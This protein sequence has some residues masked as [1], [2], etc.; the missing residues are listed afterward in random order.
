MYVISATAGEVFTYIGYVIAAVLAL[1]VMIVIHELGHYTAGKLFGFKIDEFAIGFGPA[2]IKKRNKKTGELFTL[3]PFPIGGFCAFHG[4]DAEGAMV[5][6]NGNQIKDENGN[7]VKDPDAF[8]NQ[9]PWKRL[10]VLLSGAFMNFLSAIV[11]ITIYFTAYGQLL[12]NVVDVHNTATYQNVFQEGDVIL[13]INGKQVNIMLQEDLDNA[14]KDLSD[15]SYFW[16]L[17]G[18]KR[19][20]ITA[21]KFYYQPFDEDD[22]IAVINGKKLETP[23]KASA[24]GEYVEQNEIDSAQ[25]ITLVVVKYG[26]DGKIV[27]QSSMSVQKGVVASDIDGFYSYGFGI[28]RSLTHAKLPFFLAFGRAWGFSFFIVFK[29][30]ASLGA[31]ITG[32][33]GIENAGGTITT[34]KMMAQITSLGFDSFLYV[35]AII[36]ANLAVMNL[37]PFPALDGSRMLFTLIEM[38]FRKPVPRKIEGI[39]HT[40]GLVLLIVLA[41]FLDIFHLVKG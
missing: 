25:K 12:P 21:D 26:E 39:I 11:I 31:L 4:E 24:L 19:V 15:N 23:I 32:K 16:V 33:S 37:L 28:T 22:F 17:R 14:F 7:I 8:N 29:I 38:I 34:I 1:M 36:S 30:L 41:V 20:K 2:I 18:G 27:E 9:K 5:D 6:E 10:I 3:R 35:V 13:N 40:V